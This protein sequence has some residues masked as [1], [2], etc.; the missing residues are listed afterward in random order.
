MRVK[1]ADIGGVRTR[2]LYAG[3]GPPLLLLHGVGMSADGFL[4]II[5]PLASRFSVFA[6]DLLAHGFTD[7][8]DLSGGARPNRHG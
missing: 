5:D 4:R 3:D 1:F 2:Y 6:P 7:V 8:A